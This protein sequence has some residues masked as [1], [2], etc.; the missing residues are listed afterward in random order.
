MSRLQQILTPFIALASLALIAPSAF[1][2]ELHPFVKSDGSVSHYRFMKTKYDAGHAAI[3]QE[4]L[5]NDVGADAN[6]PN[7]YQIPHSMLPAV[8]DQG[9]RGTCAYFATVGILETYYLAQSP[10]NKK[11]AL[12][13][14]CLVD[15]RN[16]MFDQ[17]DAYTGDD[18]PDQRPD[19]DGDLPFSIV[20]TVQRDGVPVA[21]KY[22]SLADCRYKS[23]SDGDDVSLANYLRV[24][25][26]NQTTSYGRG[27]SFDQS[28]K[29]TL[30]MIK[31][32]ISRN[33]P[34]EVG[35]LVYNEFGNGSDWWYNASTDTDAN[36]E[37]GHAIILTGY[38]VESSRTVFTFK[39]SW[40]TDWG[41][42]GFGT[43]DDRLLVHG[44]GYDPSFD[45]IVSLHP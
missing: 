41:H 12:S 2:G 36:L 18:K 15:L 9:Q 33:I 22:G 35:I 45:F 38:R 7:S 10:A 43:I 40:G 13:E 28:D 39:N 8:R 17:K 23:S 34:V 11:L 21:K 16:W 44:W 5:N 25:S 24:F 3:V 19:P 30:S 42:A 37:G 29:P 20:R 31:N 26:A 27:L 1:D 14:E 4:R 6:L 32:L